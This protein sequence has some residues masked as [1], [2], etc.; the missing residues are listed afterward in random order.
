MSLRPGS[1]TIKN[2]SSNEYL[3]VTTDD[4]GKYLSVV[5]EAD[6]GGPPNN[7]VVVIT[8]NRYLKHCN[9]NRSILIEILCC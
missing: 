3:A 7:F 4:A 9:F 2:R 8:M 6:N 1:Y 5:P